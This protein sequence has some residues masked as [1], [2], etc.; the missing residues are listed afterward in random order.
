MNKSNFAADLVSIFFFMKHHIT[1]V[2]I[3][4]VLIQHLCKH[5]PKNKDRAQAS[6]LLLYRA[7]LF[8]SFVF[9]FYFLNI[10]AY[11]VVLVL[12]KNKCIPKLLEHLPSQ[13]WVTANPAEVQQSLPLFVTPKLHQN[14]VSYTHLTL[15]TSV[16]V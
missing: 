5:S 4:Q 11:L 7:M 6:L 16:Y 8:R 14:A 3:H 2:F 10:L 13:V 15:P 1:D 9:C 12:P